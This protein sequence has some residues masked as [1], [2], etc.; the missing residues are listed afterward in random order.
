MPGRIGSSTRRLVGNRMALRH[1]AFIITFIFGG[2]SWSASADQLEELHL[3][4]PFLVSR[5]IP[6]YPYSALRDRHTGSV[7]VRARIASDGSVSKVSLEKSSGHKSLDDAALISAFKWK[8][9]PLPP[10]MQNE[11][12]FAILPITFSLGTGSA[13]DEDGYK[14]D[15]A[16]IHYPL[17]SRLLNENGV[18]IL[19]IRLSPEN[20]L[21]SQEI[22]FSSGIPRLDKAALKGSENMRF[23]RTTNDWPLKSEWRYVKVNFVGEV[24]LALLPS[25]PRV[26]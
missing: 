21:E 26:F 15:V 9:T 8:F 11:D 20:I 5:S 2:S 13:Q 24:E 16:Y 3:S 12:R 23:S 1:L 7:Q 4:P 19:R 6:Q 18:V 22:F 25:E 17:L 10:T 14:L